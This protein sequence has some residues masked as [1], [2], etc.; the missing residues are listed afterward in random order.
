[1]PI[2][3]STCAVFQRCATKEKKWSRL[4]QNIFEGLTPRWSLVFFGGVGK[5]F[6]I[7]EFEVQG[8]AVAAGGM[9]FRYRLARKLGLQ[10]G[11]D[12]AQG[13]EDTAIYLTVG[14]AWR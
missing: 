6:P 4:K 11:V 2:R 1:M 7:S 3:L 14:S 10:L 8:E 9:G 13:P 12:V 5:T